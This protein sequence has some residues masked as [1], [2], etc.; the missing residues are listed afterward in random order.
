MDEEIN[1][2]LGHIA[3]LICKKLFHLSLKKY[4]MSYL[5]EVLNAKIEKE[6]I[7]HSQI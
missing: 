3:Y 4:L 6:K 1:R 2:L 5:I 7:E